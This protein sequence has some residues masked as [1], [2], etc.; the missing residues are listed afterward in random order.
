MSMML[1]IT[2]NSALSRF[3]TSSIFLWLALPGLWSLCMN[4]RTLVL[5][6]QSAFQDSLICF[7]SS[8]VRGRSD[9]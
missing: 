8:S 1:R 9:S 2:S 6:A 5:A 3:M 7:H 4:L